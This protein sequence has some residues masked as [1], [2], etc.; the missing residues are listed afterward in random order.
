MLLSPLPWATVFTLTSESS[1]YLEVKESE[2]KVVHSCPTLCNPV[3]CRPPGSSVHGISQARILEWVAISVQFS[4][5]VLSDSLLPHESQHARPPCPSPTPGV[6]SNLCPLSR[7]CH[8]GISSS[9][10]PFSS[11]PQSLPASGSFPMSQLF[12][13][14]GQSIGVS[15][16]FSSAQIQPYPVPLS[17]VLK[18]FFQCTETRLVLLTLGFLLFHPVHFVSVTQSC[19]TLC[20]PMDCSM[21]G[22]PVHHQLPELTQTHVHQVGDAIQ[23]SHPLLSP[24]PP[25]FNISQHQDL[26]Q[27]VSSLHQMD[28]VLELQLQ[29]QSFQW[30]FGTD[31]L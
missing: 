24:S 14:G 2:S 5:S 11:C 22:F 7:W 30:V 28:K 17:V 19:T 31:F 4:H 12:T 27:W 10:I 9:V 16:S 23:P 29:H 18:L 26:F 1:K 6:Y 8:P 21:P 25:I 3:D 15:A 20:D 13:W